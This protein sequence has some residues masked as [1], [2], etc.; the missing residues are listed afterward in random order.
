MIASGDSYVEFTMSEA[1]TQRNIGLSNGNPGTSENEIAFALDTLALA[2]V[3]RGAPIVAGVLLGLGIAVHPGLGTLGAAAIVPAAILG[4]PLPWRAL[5]VGFPLLAVGG[6]P[7]VLIAAGQAGGSSLPAR[8]RFNLA[9]VGVLLAVA[10][11]WLAAVV[12]AFT[13]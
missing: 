3:V 1:N 7:L 11:G 4:G 13:A 6:L 9:S 8:E 12:F 10:A 2:A 5:R